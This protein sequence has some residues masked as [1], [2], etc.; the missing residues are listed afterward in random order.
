MYFLP[1]DSITGIFAINRAIHFFIFF[2]IGLTIGHY[3]LDSQIDNWTVIVV[4]T[5]GYILSYMFSLGLLTALFASI[6]FWGLAIKVDRSFTS[7]MF[8][9]FRD[10]TYQ[11]FLIGIF[12]QILI[13]IFSRKMIFPGSYAVWWL[14]CVLLGIYIP[15]IISRIPFLKDNKLFRRIT[16]L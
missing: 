5:I 12:V 3:D 6:G 1:V 7:N 10:Y 15:V 14:L 4:C 11:I 16:G 2:F 9:S 13:K 8:H